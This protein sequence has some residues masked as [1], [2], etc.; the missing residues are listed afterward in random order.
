MEKY[1]GGQI[2][3]DLECKLMELDFPTGQVSSYEN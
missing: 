1:T 3:E 2:M